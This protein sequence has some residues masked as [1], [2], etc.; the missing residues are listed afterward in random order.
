MILFTNSLSHFI[1]RGPEV[2]L[3]LNLSN[4]KL[5]WPSGD[6]FPEFPSNIKRVDGLELLG[7]AIWGDDAFFKEF[8]CCRID[9]VTSIKEKLALLEDPQLELHLIFCEVVSAATKLSI[10]LEQFLL[11]CYNHFFVNLT[12]TFSTVSAVL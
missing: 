1:S 5:F 6:S 12:L 3:D 2:G 7:S 11:L 8:L 10:Y 9:K 4:C